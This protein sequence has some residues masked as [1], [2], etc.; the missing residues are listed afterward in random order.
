M[1]CLWVH[2]SIQ[3]EI[4]ASRISRAAWGVSGRAWSSSPWC[5]WITGSLIILGGYIYIWY[6]NIW[7]MI[8]DMWICEYVNICDMYIDLFSHETSKLYHLAY[9]IYEYI[10]HQLDQNRDRWHQTKWMPPILLG[11]SGTLGRTGIT[12]TYLR[13]VSP[14]F[15]ST[16][17][18]TNGQNTR[19]EK[20]DFEFVVP[21][22]FPLFFWY[23]I[24]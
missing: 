1:F 16:T 2:Y 17:G 13:Q 24:H 4:G 7:Y 11:K 5:P 21:H 6:T 12:W 20:L 19:M 23:D 18:S 22:D 14:D 3:Q 15:R 10:W 9:W 8:C